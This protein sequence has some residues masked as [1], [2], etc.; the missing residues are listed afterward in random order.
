MALIFMRYLM[1]GWFG[2][3]ANGNNL[4]NDGFHGVEIII[5]H[6]EFTSRFVAIFNPGKFSFIF[7]WKF[8]SMDQK[9]IFQFHIFRNKLITKFH[10]T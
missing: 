6:G 8:H 5:C 4:I 1:R 9:H 3:I 2:I 7:T 10:D